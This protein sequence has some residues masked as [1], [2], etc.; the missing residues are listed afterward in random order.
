MYDSVP[1]SP[2]LSWLLLKQSLRYTV[3]VAFA[4]PKYL[5]PV[6]LQVY[7]WLECLVIAVC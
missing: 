3:D 7:T 2:F 1:P 5:V 6:I 4:L